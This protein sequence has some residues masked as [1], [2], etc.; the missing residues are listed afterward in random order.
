M[1]IWR[2][3][4]RLGRSGMRGVRV[5]DRRLYRDSRYRGCILTLDEFLLKPL[6]ALVCIL[7]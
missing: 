7:V 4:T 6:V 5:G 1:T 2:A 3:R